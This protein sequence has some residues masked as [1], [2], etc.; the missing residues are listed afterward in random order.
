MLV[1]LYRWCA[2]W[3]SPF[4]KEGWFATLPGDDDLLTGLDFDILAN[5]G[6][7]KRERHSRGC[8]LVEQFPL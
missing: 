5:M 1:Y 8:R 3:P 2:R 7:E 4:R 6:F